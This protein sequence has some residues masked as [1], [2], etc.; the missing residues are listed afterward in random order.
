MKKYFIYTFGCQQNI[1]DSERIKS[2]FKKINY[3]ATSQIKEADLIIINSCSI[4]Q[5]AIDRLRGLALKIKKIK[6]EN[7]EIKSILTGCL[8]EKD[9]K[10]FKE[11]FDFILPI[12]TLNKWPQII[13]KKASYPF[14]NQR[15][16]DFVENNGIDY[17][18]IQPERGNHFS[19]L[20][21]I[22]SGCNNFCTYCVVPFT[23]GPLICRG[24]KKILQEV[25]QAIKNGAKEI[26]LHGENVNDYLSPSQKNINFSSLLKKIDKLKGDFWIRFISSHPKN[27]SEE[28]INQLPKIE[29]LA[30]HLHIP[31]QSGSNNILKKMNR[32]YSVKD[33]KIL[34]SKIR[35]K[36]PNIA[37]TTDVIVGFPGETKKDFQETVNLFKEIKFDMAYIAKYSKREG[38]KAAQIKDNV[39][40]Q[41]KEDRRKKLNNVLEKTALQNNKKYLNKKIKV[42]INDKTD[43]YFL[44][45]TSSYKT[46]KFK[47]NQLMKVGEFAN[48]FIQ[49]VS[50][51][52][53]EGENIPQKMIVILGPTASG[54]TSIS[55]KLAQ[56]FNGEIVSSDSK[57]VYKEIGIGTAKPNKEEMKNIPHYLINCVSLKDNFNVAIYK[58]KA[59]QAIRKIIK[60]EKTPFLVGGSPLYTKSVVENFSL[61]QTKPNKELRKKLENKNKKE[62]FD[63]Y[64]KLDPKGAKKIKKKNKRR[65]IRAIEVCKESGE[66]FWK[67][68]E[69]D[70]SLFNVL[71]I[72]IKPDKERLKERISK[73]TDQMFEQGLEKEAI[74]VIKK[75]KPSPILKVIGYQEWFPFYPDFKIDKQSRQK[76]KEKIKLHT[77][78]FSKRQMTW[79][80]KDK[81]INW[82]NNYSEA[83]EKIKKFLEG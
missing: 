44:A 67:Q 6:K 62:L 56:K 46:V 61:A 59:F 7:K 26:W 37:I 16:K 36:I 70:K 17:F 4:R 63:I 76:I 60:K 51:W 81:E 33:F 14:F 52:G 48:I 77:L 47:K 19:A 58:K 3:Q 71:K 41:E 40:L 69:K 25:R 18:N 64:K 50:A 28:L 73:R 24:H 9:R 78:Q 42:L 72:G 79:Y 55:I 43:N 38:T 12:K 45:K 34:I 22:S 31:V 13:K 83:E 75:F 5:S 10:K 74:K 57:Q 54:K 29:K 66:S 2:V 30:Q 15:D 23:R 21:P 32:S 27:F 80:K 53:L 82:V 68:R 65:L 49:D 20:I 39:S 11:Y 35:N 8:L 1:S